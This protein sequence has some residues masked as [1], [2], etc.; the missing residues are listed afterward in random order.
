M[1]VLLKQTGNPRWPEEAV[2]INA[3]ELAAMKKAKTVTHVEANVYREKVAEYQT[4]E[5]TPR[6]KR[7]SKKSD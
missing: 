4:K 1:Y 7:T 5:M 6:K 3:D 2:G